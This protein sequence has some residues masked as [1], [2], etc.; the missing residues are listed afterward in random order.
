MNTLWWKYRN[1]ANT[2]GRTAKITFHPKHWFDQDITIEYLEFLLDYYPR[3]KIGLIWDACKAHSTPLVLQFIAQHPRL[4]VVGIFGG[5]TSVIQVRLMLDIH[6]HICCRLTSVIQVCDLIANKDL[7]HYIKDGYYKWHTEF[8]AEKK[9]E[10]ERAGGSRNN[11]RIKMKMPIN[12]MTVIV[13]DGVKQF[14]TKQC[15]KPTVQNMFRRVN[16]DPW[17]DFKA[18]FERHLDSLQEDSMYKTLHDNNN[19]ANLE[20]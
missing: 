18:E 2:P 14:N 9:A 15:S 11:A 8:I 7:K 3:E 19:A 12:K 5:L 20:S 16:H 1:W 6:I 13:E 17:N 4:I 10:I